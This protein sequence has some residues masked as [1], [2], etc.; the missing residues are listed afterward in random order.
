MVKY[1]LFVRFL[2]KFRFIDSFN[3]NV[4]DELKFLIMYI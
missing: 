4:I 3:H 1:E 2:F